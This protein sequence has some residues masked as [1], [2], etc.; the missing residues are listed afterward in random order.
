MIEIKLTKIITGKDLAESFEEEY[1]SIENLENRLKKD[2]ENMQLFS[3][4]EDWKFFGKNPDDEIE[5][6]TTI[7]TDTL[8][9]TNL[10][11]ELLNFIKNEHPQSIRELARMIQEDVSNT[12]RRISRLVKEGL[13]ELK[14]GSRNSK[15]PTLNYDKIEIAI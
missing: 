8:T 2:S 12:Q 5:D 9:L 11:L 15:V 10:E 1:G 13:L 6:T 4:L 7:I 3:D 14:K